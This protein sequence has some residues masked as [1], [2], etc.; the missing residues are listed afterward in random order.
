MYFHCHPGIY[1]TAGGGKF[2]HF[3]TI[4]LQFLLLKQC[5]SKGFGWSQTAKN[6]QPPAAGWS[7][8]K[9]PPSA[10]SGNFPGGF[11]IRGGAFLT[12]IPLIST[13]EVVHYHFDTQKLRLADALL[14][15]APPPLPFVR[16]WNRPRLFIYSVLFFNNTKTGSHLVQFYWVQISTL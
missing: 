3:W 13:I 10:Q 8:K 1:C 14:R 9:A 12:L 15:E 5:I 16:F 7:V 2:L 4:F 11:L 6:F